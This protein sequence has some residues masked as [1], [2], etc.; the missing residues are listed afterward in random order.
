MDGARGALGRDLVPGDRPQRLRRRPDRRRSSRCTRSRCASWAARRSA[1]ILLSLALLPRRARRAAAADGAR[2][3]RRGGALDGVGA[4]LL[5]DGRSSSPR[6]TASR[7]SWPSPSAAC[8]PPGA[9]TGP[10]RGS[11][12]ALAAATRVDGRGGGARAVC[13]SCPPAAAAVSGADRLTRLAWVALVPARAGRVSGRAGAGATWTGTR[14]STPRTSGIAQWAGPLGGVWDGAKAAWD[15]RAPARRRG[16]AGRAHLLPDRR[17]R[18]AGHRA[19]QPRAV[20]LGP[21]R[22]CRARRRGA[23]AAARLRRLRRRLARRAR[24]PI[25]SSRSR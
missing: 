22:R 11:S 16:G 12:A 20:P 17:R 4:G 24:S 10:G 14:R 2:A 3:R 15:G 7:C 19:H 18:P 6:S 21:A 8:S 25:R 13:C 23:T 9:I 5:A 1:G